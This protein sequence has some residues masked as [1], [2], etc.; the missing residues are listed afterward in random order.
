MNVFLVDLAGL[1]LPLHLGSMLNHGVGHQVLG[2]PSR[3]CYVE[4]RAKRAEDIQGDVL[5]VNNTCDVDL[6]DPDPEK[7]REIIL[8]ALDDRVGLPGRHDDILP[9][10][11]HEGI[12]PGILAV[13]LSFHAVRVDH[14]L[15]FVAPVICPSMSVVSQV[16]RRLGR[17]RFTGGYGTNTGQ[18]RVADN[19]ACLVGRVIELAPQLSGAS[20]GINR[21]TSCLDDFQSVSTVKRG[22]HVLAAV[23]TFVGWIIDEFAFGEV[24]NISRRAS[25][26]DYPICVCIAA[27]RR[28]RGGS[29][30]CRVADIM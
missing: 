21:V 26:P 24:T 28:E 12:A 8:G 30:D 25:G 20:L 11:I 7:P 17:G 13:H 19:N 29:G 9:G 6:K 16:T 27:G 15:Q 14:V 22:V 1:L 4:P 10:D 23:G 5:C 2:L 3:V 18:A